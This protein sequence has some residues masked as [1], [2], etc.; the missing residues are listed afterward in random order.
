MVFAI[1]RTAYYTFSCREY[2]Q[3]G[4]GA[5]TSLQQ[6]ATIRTC[7]ERLCKHARFCLLDQMVNN[8]RCMRCFY[9]ILSFFYACALTKH[10]HTRNRKLRF[11]SRSESDGGADLGPCFLVSV[12][13]A[14]KLQAIIANQLCGNGGFSIQKVRKNGVFVSCQR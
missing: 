6:Y 13:H 2:R 4:S 5:S 3:R 12:R 14:I 11:T 9:P 1:I 10:G 8:I 7:I